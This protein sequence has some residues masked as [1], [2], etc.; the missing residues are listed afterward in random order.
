MAMSDPEHD[1]LE[2]IGFDA[3]FQSAFRELGDDAAKLIPARIAVA[4]G[5][6][7]LAWTSRGN[8]KAIL[9]GRRIADWKQPAQRPQ[10][11]DWVAGTFS[12]SADSLMIE[13][14]LPRRT[15]LMRAAAGERDQ[16]QVVAANVD[17]VGVV[18]AFGDATDSDA[19][20]RRLINERR[21][22]RYLSAVAQGGAQA[23]L[24]L[25]K[26]DLSPRATAVADELGKR[27]SPVPVLITSAESRAGLD[28]L[29]EWLKPAMTFGLVG[30]SGVG[31]STLVNA[32]LDRPAQ[33]TAEVRDQDARGRHT[34]THREL[35]VTPSGVL[36]IDTPG[37]REFGLWE[38]DDLA[39]FEDVTALAAGCRFGDCGHGNEPDCAVR[40]A[41]EAGTLT[42]AR[43]ASY[44]TL[45]KEID[46]R[47]RRKL[48]QSRRPVRRR[49]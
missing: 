14:L 46:R 22:E 40:R 45:Q 18:S 43:W 2:R 13:H 26:S 19:R 48:E 17:L 32:L 39:S 35:F 27:F 34:T 6:S 21:L 11:G 31:K 47:E 15:C 4:H 16:A 25:N 1:D 37:M 28:R 3:H 9:V 42:A 38:V 24:I 12:E 29:G 20:E 49:R 10:V 33:R 44:Q 8:C 30:M 5:E 41:L 36:L 23:V 7:Y